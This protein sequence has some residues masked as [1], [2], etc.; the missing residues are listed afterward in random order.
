MLVRCLQTVY[1]SGK[2]YGR[3]DGQ[4]EWPDELKDSAI[5]LCERGYLELIEETPVQEVAPKG[6]R[7][8]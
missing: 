5:D 7:G 2:Q 4:F 1:L 6:K 3:D 8:G